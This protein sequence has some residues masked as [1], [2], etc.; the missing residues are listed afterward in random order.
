MLAQIN[1]DV[2]YFILFRTLVILLF[3][4]I[5]SQIYATAKDSTSIS[6]QVIHQQKKQ[7]IRLSGSLTSNTLKRIKLNDIKNHAN[8]TKPI[9]LGSFAI[10]SNIKGR[11]RLDFSSVN[12]F[13]L[14][15]STLASTFLTSYQL[16]LN[17]QIIN[18]HKKTIQ[19]SSCSF[20]TKILTLNVSNAAGKLQNTKK[21]KTGYY[22]DTLMIT[23]TA[24]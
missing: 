23:V 3:L 22:W 5:S 13:R 11:C 8:N 10:Q 6:I 17:K 12:Q 7:K 14:K 4:A 18:N 16:S 20:D 1:K 21:F 9:K 19:N 24:P 2:V 15:H